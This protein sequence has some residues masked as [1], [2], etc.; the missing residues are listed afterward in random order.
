MQSSGCVP[1]YGPISS[2]HIRSQFSSEIEVNQATLL[3]T[4]QSVALQ[5]FSQQYVNADDSKVA[6]WMNFCPKKTTGLDFEIADRG[7]VKYCRTDS[8]PLF[9]AS[10]NFSLPSFI[11]TLNALQYS[12]ISWQP[13]INQQQARLFLHSR[14]LEQL[15]RDD[16]RALGVPLPSSLQKIRTQNRFSPP[17]PRT[18]QGLARPPRSA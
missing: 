11:F 1:R 5:T 18:W 13:H 9:L 3:L 17:R 7:A 8:R 16:C 2:P 4:W 10:C 14:F 6:S 15:F 12:G